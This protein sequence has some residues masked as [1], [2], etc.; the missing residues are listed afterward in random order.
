MNPT[1]FTVSGVFLVAACALGQ[2]RVSASY[3]LT[4]ET[5]DGGGTK[6]TT[7]DYVMQAS[8][9]GFGEIATTTMPSQTLKPGFVGQIY[10]LVTLQLTAAP[11]VV[12]E[13]GS[14]R[15]SATA[16]LDDASLLGLSGSTVAWRVLQGPVS[17]I[18]SNGVA[19]IGPVYETTLATVR[20]EYLLRAGTVDLT[21]LNLGLDDYGLYANDGIADTWQVD[22]FGPDNPDG[23]AS[24][25]PDGDG[26]PNFMEALAGTAPSDPNSKFRFTPGLHSPGR[27]SFAFSPRLVN[28][29]YTI[30]STPVLGG[31]PFAPLN[32]VI[33]TDQ[34][35]TRTVTDTNAVGGA[36]FYRVRISQP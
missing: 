1:A 36:R 6:A 22:N 24:S 2:T 5:F 7:A 17:H 12:S 35:V 25:D 27:Q 15:L 33:Q 18:T 32:N 11:S 8:L 10:D 21:V 28:R 29:R 3:K 26:Q 31:V 19:A 9:D 16:V 14:S 13:G 4:A 30:E 23:L 34:G 20:G